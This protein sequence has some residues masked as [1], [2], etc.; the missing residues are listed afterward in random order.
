MRIVRLCL[1][2]MMAVSLVASAQPLYKWVDKNG[3]VHYSDQPPPKEIKKVDQP[4]LGAS[5]IETSGLPYEAQKAAQDFPVTLYTTPDCSA[6]CASAREFLSRRGIPFRESRV[7]TP[8]DGDAFKQALKTD[9]LL[10][11][12]MT[13]GSQ[14]QLGFE[15][16]TWHSLLDVAGYPRT[17]IPGAAS[18]TAPDGR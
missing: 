18:R 14:R 7:V 13:V 8:T 9:K 2:S 5:T 6:A 16:D 10:F 3:K 12:A 17:A 1:L 15:E 11:P 4:R